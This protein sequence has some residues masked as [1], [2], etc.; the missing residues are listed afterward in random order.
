MTDISNLLLCVR[1]IL[2]AICSDAAEL[3]GYA[4]RNKVL[5]DVHAKCHELLICMIIRGSPLSTLYKVIALMYVVLYACQ[6]W[7]L[8]LRE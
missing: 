5:R 2:P 1:E 4:P 3:L 6:M 8:T 7:S